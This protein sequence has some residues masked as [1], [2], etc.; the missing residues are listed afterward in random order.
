MRYLLDTHTLLWIAYD[1]HKLS[2]EVVAILQNT[3]NEFLISAVSVW[4]INIKF[5]IGKLTLK[6]QTPKDLFDGFTTFFRCSYL[7]LNLN[8]TLNFYKLKTFHHRDPFDRMMVWQAIQ[9]NLTFITDDEQ[10]HK[11]TD[12][13]LKV[14][15]K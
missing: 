1:Q 5:S 6:E 3:N 4:E 7:D 12:C 9:N 13:G 10:I 14:V 2:K 15:W 11:Y 8:D